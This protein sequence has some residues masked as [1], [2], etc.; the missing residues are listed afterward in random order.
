MKQEKAFVSYSFSQHHRIS[1]HAVAVREFGLHLFTRNVIP[2]RQ[3]MVASVCL[4]MKR[5]PITELL[6][7]PGH[8][9]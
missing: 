2:N 8:H 1:M 7:S 5:L 3:Q 4:L 6:A 9:S